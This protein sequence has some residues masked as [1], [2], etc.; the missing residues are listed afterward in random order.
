LTAEAKASLRING[1]W[2]IP[3]RLALQAVSL[4][5]ANDEVALRIHVDRPNQLT[6][7]DLEALGIA[8]LPLLPPACT[9]KLR[10]RRKGLL[11]SRS[12]A[13][14]PEWR[15]V[16]GAVPSFAPQFNH[17]FWQ[18]PEGSVRQTFPQLRALES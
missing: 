3:W 13:V 7:E 8:L 5:E 11:G 16:D 12:A 9:Y 2:R 14:V 6:E 4:A 17:G 15:A 18:G 10:I 1:S